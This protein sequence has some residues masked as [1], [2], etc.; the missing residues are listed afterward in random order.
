MC[1][2][3]RTA[4]GETWYLDDLPLISKWKSLET[5]RLLDIPN[6][7]GQFLIEVGKQCK[8]LR[9]LEFMNVRYNEE[10]L[11]QMLQHC[12]NLRYFSIKGHYAR[13]A[14]PGL[15]A[16]LGNN[17]ELRK[18]DLGHDTYDGTSCASLIKHL[19]LQCPM[20]TTLLIDKLV[21][22]ESISLDVSRYLFRIFST[23]SMNFSFW[24]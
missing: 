23:Q 3:Y 20:L 14:I 16:L 4:C 21:V 1:M 10:E 19:S 2:I 11:L 12:K 22:N 6:K 5:L 18:V 8:N 24:R 15:F 9:T 17:P 13:F 7:D